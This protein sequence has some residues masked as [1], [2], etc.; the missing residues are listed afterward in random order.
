MSLKYTTLFH[1]WGNGHDKSILLK[2][3]GD[4]EF[5]TV[6]TIR[7]ALKGGSASFDRSYEAT[8]D[9]AIFEGRRFAY[10]WHA[11]DA[12][13]MTE[14][15]QGGSR[16]GGDMH[17]FAAAYTCAQ[18]GID[19]GKV[20]YVGMAPPGLMNNARQ[21]ILDAFTFMKRT[22]R[23]GREV[24]IQLWNDV[25]P[26]KWQWNEVT[27]MAEGQA[28]V[29]AL[30]LDDDGNPVPSDL[31]SGNVAWIDIGAR[32][33]DLG[34]VVAGKLTSEGLQ[35]VS[36][37]RE[38]IYQSIVLPIWEMVQGYN[39]AFAHI[40]AHAVDAAIVEGPDDD[41]HYF[42]SHGGQALNISQWVRE[43]S[44]QYASWLCNNIIEQ[45][46]AGFEPYDQAIIVG[47]GAANPYIM[48][49]LYGRYSNIADLS[50]YEHLEDI[51]PGNLNVFGAMRWYQNH[52]K[53]Q[54]RG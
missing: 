33:V 27:V 43:A 6:P 17:Q 31:I 52:H 35:R 15:E 22:K 32:T 30:L 46:F 23:H 41:G 7:A 34:R 1:D 14:T 24:C 4:Y 3:N 37:E 19:R 29:F 25:E 8:F 5:D 38:G 51:N 10:G 45:Q 2:P 53:K 50:R 16:Y 9:H 40:P 20:N 12:G 49:Y 28:A 11:L 21:S 26:R 54:T 36:R 42:I 47:G 13:V 44:E 39:R 48:E 18:Y